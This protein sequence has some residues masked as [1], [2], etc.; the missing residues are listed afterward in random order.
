MGHSYQTTCS[1]DTYRE[2]LDGH[3]TVAFS[4]QLSRS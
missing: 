3:G 1:V 2:L 4:A